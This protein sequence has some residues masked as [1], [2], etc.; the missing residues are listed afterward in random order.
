MLWKLDHESTGEFFNSFFLVLLN[1]NECFY[2][3]IET[4]RTCFLFPLNTAPKK[5]RKELVYFDH[6]HVNSFCSRHY[7]VNSSC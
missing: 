6:Q 7:H 5:K 3:S 1:F 2:D 4:R